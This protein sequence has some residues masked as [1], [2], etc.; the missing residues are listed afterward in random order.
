MQ[1]R[2]KK[3]LIITLQLK[4]AEVYPGS[5]LHGTVI[6]QLMHKHNTQ[7]HRS[8]SIDSIDLTPNIGNYNISTLS[9]S[10]SSPKNASSNIVI[11]D[12][13]SISVSGICNINP[14]ADTSH[15]PS[16]LKQE[17]DTFNILRGKENI[18]GRAL[19]LKQ[20]HG[21]DDSTESIQFDFVVQLPPVLPCSYSG[22]FIQYL[23]YA[24]LF[25][26]ISKHVNRTKCRVPFYV[27]PI[28]STLSNNND[29]NHI[30]NGK[31]AIPNLL[32]PMNLQERMSIFRKRKKSH[33]SHSHSHSHNN[34]NHHHHHRLSLQSASSSSSI[35]SYPSYTT[36]P[37]NTI[38]IKQKD[39]KDIKNMKDDNIYKP[40]PSLLLPASDS[41]FIENNI[42]STTHSNL[43]KLEEKDNVSSYLF[44]D[45][46][47]HNRDSNSLINED[48]HHH[49]S[50]G[51]ND[52]NINNNDNNLMI[53][54]KSKI[55]DTNNKFVIS[56][57]ENKS[58][59]CL[60]LN[61]TIFCDGECIEGYLSLYTPA[62]VKVT[63][64]H[65]ENCGQKQKHL[66]NCCS[67]YECCWDSPSFTFTLKIPNNAFKS[68]KSDL[69]QSSWTLHFEFAISKY[70]LSNKSIIQSE[71]YYDDIKDNTNNNNHEVIGYLNTSY[72][73]W[74]LH[75]ERD[76]NLN[77]YNQNH[78]HNHN[79][80]DQVKQKKIDD[81]QDIKQVDKIL[82]WQLP[83]T[84]TTVH[85]PLR[86]V[87]RSNA[88]VVKC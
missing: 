27:L 65:I 42:L 69:C 46:S 67:S 21:D 35:S 22:Y 75:E 6:L 70:L 78:S 48:H 64:V 31:L 56:L 19:Q 32:T 29:H 62:I 13:V 86:C 15:F 60:L 74:K 80:N 18:L 68:F 41:H 71:S 20:Q 81:Q 76:I 10:S 36:S 44:N 2:H 7:R 82:K 47:T 63:L 8:S 37:S 83:I 84:V 53:R 16:H 85:N 59:G 66:T 25:V 4:N 49:H 88:V 45:I 23:Y 73:V 43:E 30:N 40:S 51:L 54:Y 14:F 52:R 17:N 1:V 38:S 39:I 11:I 26:T 77:H 50:H 33:H 58:I 5:N 57:G 72:D 28:S 12:N 79:H 87:T 55:S 3:R 34:S 61:D 24:Q 9:S